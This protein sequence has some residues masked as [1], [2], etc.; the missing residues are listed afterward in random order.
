MMAVVQCSQK[1]KIMDQNTN[2]LL[3]V[4]EAGN[5]YRWQV[6]ISSLLLTGIL[7][8]SDDKFLWCLMRNWF[9]F[10]G[11]VHMLMLRRIPRLHLIWGNVTP[12]ENGQ[13]DSSS[14]RFWQ[15]GFL[16]L[17]DSFVVW[18]FECPMQTFWENIYYPVIFSQNLTQNC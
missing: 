7:K 5:Q 17:L 16:E 9:L 8:L 2:H 11:D 14:W 6:Y 4:N 3:R 13:E 15:I 18:P 1:N 10:V 12:S